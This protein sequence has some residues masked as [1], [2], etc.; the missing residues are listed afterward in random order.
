[1]ST[2]NTLDKI[3]VV[4][5]Y[6]PEHRDGDRCTYSEEEADELKQKYVAEGYPNANFD[7]YTQPEFL[8]MGVKKTGLKDI[9]EF[10]YYILDKY[11][12]PIHGVIRIRNTTDGTIVVSPIDKPDEQFEMKVTHEELSRWHFLRT[13]WNNRDNLDWFEKF[14]F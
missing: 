9:Q 6:Y 2:E 12:C 1:M 7:S 3:Y 10:D 11:Q 13:A 8:Q 5:K 14:K 4:R